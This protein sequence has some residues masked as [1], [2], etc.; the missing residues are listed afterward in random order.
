M[1]DGER[2]R[3][4]RLQL[5]LS[6]ERLGEMIGQD[7]GYISRLERGDLKEITVTTL[8]K[9]VRALRVSADYLLGFS[10]TMESKTEAAVA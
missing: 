6:Q 9:I 8:S 4:R 7:Q 10:D 3:M 5:R 1:L 2:L